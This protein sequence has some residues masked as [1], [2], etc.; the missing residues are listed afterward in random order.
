MRYRHEISKISPGFKN[1]YD[2]VSCKQV[3]LRDTLGQE[4]IYLSV[5]FHLDQKLP[6]IENVEMLNF[7]S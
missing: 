4:S 7:F 2:L 1:K 5:K 6:K 3:I